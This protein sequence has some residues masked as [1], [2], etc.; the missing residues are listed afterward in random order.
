M[1]TLRLFLKF[2]RSEWENAPSEFRTLVE[3]IIFTY[4]FVSVISA[5]TIPIFLLNG[6]KFS[7]EIIFFFV[8]FSVPVYMF[9]IYYIIKATYHLYIRWGYFLSTGGKRKNEDTP[10]T[11]EIPEPFKSILDEHDRVDPIPERYK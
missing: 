3:V 7:S 8:G 4:R 10:I 2:I 5:A 11:S 9:I 6:G 1:Y